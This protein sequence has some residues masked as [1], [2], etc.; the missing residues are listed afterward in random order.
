MQQAKKKQNKTTTNNKKHKYT[1]P[2]GG[3][4]VAA[5]IFSVPVFGKED[6][7]P[8]GFRTV[9]MFLGFVV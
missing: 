3:E 1:V 2:R 7:S 9:L 8:T 5:D 4:M 6:T